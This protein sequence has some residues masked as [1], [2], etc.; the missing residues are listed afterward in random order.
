MNPGDGGRSDPPDAG[1]PPGD[2]T[3]DSTADPR[4]DGSDRQSRDD[5]AGGDA[6]TGGRALDGG[7]GGVERGGSPPDRLDP[8][9]DARPGTASE[10]AAG[11]VPADVDAGGEDAGAGGAASPLVRLRTDDEGP[12]RFLREVLLNVGAVVLVGLVLFAVSGVWPPMVAVESGSMEPHMHRGDLVLITEP[13]RFAPDAAERGTGVVTYEAG[14]DVGYRSFGDYGSVVVYDNPRRGGPPVIHRAHFYVEAGEDWYS[15]ANPDYLAADSC[16]ELESCPA[17]QAGYITK[18]DANA[19]YDQANGISGPVRPG[20]ITGVARVRIP[21]LGWVRLALSWV[22]GPVPVVEVAAALPDALPTVD[23]AGAAA[24]PPAPAT[25][26]V[27]P[28]G[29]AP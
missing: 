6:G 14:R 16:A 20:W 10:S 26:A 12:Y 18:G 2:E 21:L 8:R 1:G 19:N 3:P 25:T 9:E 23:V 27:G 5:P 15:R 11:A 17:G 13:G 22:S 24:G 4:D 29:P 7:D 28:T